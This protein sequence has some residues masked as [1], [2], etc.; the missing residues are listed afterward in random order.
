MTRLVSLD[1]SNAHLVAI[2]Q[3][4]RNCDDSGNGL[5]NS[6]V[7]KMPKKVCGVRLCNTIIWW[8]MLECEI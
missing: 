8:I 3:I 6:T 1:V 4:Q 5:R 2:K 7:E